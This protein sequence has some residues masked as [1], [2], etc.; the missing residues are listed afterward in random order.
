[1]SNQL[2]TQKSWGSWTV[3]S[4]CPRKV[5]DMRSAPGKVPEWSRAWNSEQSLA[6]LRELRSTW[7]PVVDSTQNRE[8]SIQRG[9]LGQVVK[10]GI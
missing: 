5:P 4:C 10:S 7:D 1:M 2:E 8:M 9:G 6:R 3:G